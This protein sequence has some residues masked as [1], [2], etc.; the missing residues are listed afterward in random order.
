MFYILVSFCLFGRKKQINYPPLCEIYKPRDVCIIMTKH[1]RK[2]DIMSEIQN[3][4][5]GSIKG[6]AW[7]KKDRGTSKYDL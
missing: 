4:T 7:S 6:K 5:F 2:P 3:D 1:I